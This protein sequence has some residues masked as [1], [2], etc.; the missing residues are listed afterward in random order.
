MTQDN[1][2]YQR[3]ILTSF[4]ALIIGS[5]TLLFLLFVLLFLLRFFGVIKPEHVK[6]PAKEPEKRYT[7]N[8]KREQQKAP[9]RMADNINQNQQESETKKFLSDKNSKSVSNKPK[10]T[11]SGDIKLDKQSQLNELSLAEGKKGNSKTESEGKEKPKESES[12]EKVSS[13][14]NQP[15]NLE[16]LFG[17]PV[18]KKEAAKAEKGN[19]YAQNGTSPKTIFSSTSKQNGAEILGTDISLSTYAWEWYPYI[20]NMKRKIYQFWSV[21]PAYG[22]GLISGASRIHITISR[23]GKMTYYKLL[24]HNGSESLQKS[25]EDVM[26]AIFDLP[27]LPPDFP[28]PEL[29]FTI[30]LIYPKLQR[31]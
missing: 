16:S 11:H 19:P 31:R 21:P 2:H 13:V 29:S 3:S 17:K 1:T 24:G 4:Y 9:V 26:L 20:Q 7:V 27:T 30:T 28:D 23:S 18:E 12:S 22:L 15:N 6:A 14:F 25:S 8:L 10:E 5:G